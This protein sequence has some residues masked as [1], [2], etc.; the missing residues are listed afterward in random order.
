MNLTNVFK[1]ASSGMSAQNIR[2]N[3]IASNISNAESV[4]S[5]IN[6]T[7]RARHPVF[8]ATLNGVKVKAIVE[9]QS[10][11]KM[12]Y[13]PNHPKADQNGYVYY[14]NVNIVAEMADMIAAS[15][16][17]QTNTEVFNNAKQMVLQSLNLGK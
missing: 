10:E 15:R 3:T 4:S 7:Y 11:L 1:I 16:S 2:L 9:D 14:P 13:E 5:S 17:Y 8:A 12:R 6:S